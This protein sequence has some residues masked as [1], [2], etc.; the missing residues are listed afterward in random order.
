[1]TFQELIADQE[2]RD[3]KLL[4][5]IKAE[6]EEF[7]LY[8]SMT[9]VQSARI[10]QFRITIEEFYFDFIVDCSK[11]ILGIKG[12]TY[13]RLTWSGYEYHEIPL[14]MANLDELLMAIASYQDVYKPKF[15]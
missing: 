7:G 6:I 13:Q 11:L 2:K 12:Y 1:M 3:N 5:D 8:Y 4:E 10:Y 15:E 9:S 14:T